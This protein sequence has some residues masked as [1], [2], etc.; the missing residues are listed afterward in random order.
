VFAYV[1]NQLDIITRLLLYGL[2]SWI[3]GDMIATAIAVHYAN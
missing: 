3:A 1:D 2:D